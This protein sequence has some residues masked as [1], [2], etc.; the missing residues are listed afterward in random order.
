MC[1]TFLQPP[2]A[3]GVIL[4]SPDQADLRQKI[5]A[6][7]YPFRR[8]SRVHRAHWQNSVGEFPCRKWSRF[9]GLSKADATLR[10]QDF[11]IDG[12]PVEIIPQNDGKFT[13]RA[14]Y[15][16]DMELPGAKP[17]PP[18]PPEPDPQPQQTNTQPQQGGTQPQQ[19]NTQPQQ[20]GTQPQQT[21]TQPQQGGTQPQQTNTQ[22][23]AGRHPASTDQHATPADEHAA[24]TEQH[25]AAA[26][27]PSGSTSHC[28]EAFAKGAGL[29][30]AFE[31]CL[32]P[33]NGSYRAYFDPVKVL[34]IGWGHTN[35]NG[36]QITPSSVWTRAEC[37]AE[38]LADMAIF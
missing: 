37:D 21:N 1:G 12:V 27:R 4:N 15:P 23:H 33:V 22:P 26:D 24:S 7:I 9:P 29:V 3:I 34:T 13:V 38:F 6:C 5:S 8:A 17:L 36:R 28:P 2:I 18:Q 16:D 19:T 20:G 32:H 31:S 14:T 35:H 25:T 11:G 30:K 10:A